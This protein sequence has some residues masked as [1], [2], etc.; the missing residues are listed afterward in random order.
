MS[1]HIEIVPGVEGADGIRLDGTLYPASAV[2]D[3]LRERPR[4]AQLAQAARLAVAVADAHRSV[5]GQLAPF[6]EQAAARR[7]LGH[8]DDA[9]AQVWAALAELVGGGADG[10]RVPRR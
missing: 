2:A 8:L 10:P 4:L 1:H 7:L 9:E 6:A 3:A 5:R